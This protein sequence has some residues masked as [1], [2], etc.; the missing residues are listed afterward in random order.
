MKHIFTFLILFSSCFAFSQ[1]LQPTD[2]MALITVHVKNFKGMPSIGD[3][4]AFKSKASGKEYTGV[5]KPNGTFQILLPEGDSYTVLVMGFEMDNTNNIFNVPSN[6]GPTRGTYTITYELP[7]TYTL[8]NLYFDTGKA[9]I[10]KE[11]YS[12][13]NDLAELMKRKKTMVIQLAGHTDNVGSEESNQKLSETRA[14]S[15][16]RYLISKG[17]Q[18]IRVI[19]VGYGQSQPIASNSTAEG[20]QQ[21]R[22]TEVKILHE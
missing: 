18:A 1:N 19:A 4:V 8:N 10:R 17:V 16:K 9:T 13:L 5:S 21:N 11:S 3:K 7:K 22:R 2:D 12:S 6:P 14:E 20:R 15:V